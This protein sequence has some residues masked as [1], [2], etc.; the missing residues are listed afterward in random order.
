MYATVHYTKNYPVK[1]KSH[2]NFE[3]TLKLNHAKRIAKNETYR[4]NVQLRSRFPFFTT[5][6]FIQHYSFE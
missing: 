1:S 2:V 6:C 5:L 4:Y 3:V